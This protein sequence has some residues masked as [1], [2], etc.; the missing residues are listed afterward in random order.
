MI[1]LRPSDAVLYK[2]TS[3]IYMNYFYTLLILFPR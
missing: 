3:K 1:L 2:G